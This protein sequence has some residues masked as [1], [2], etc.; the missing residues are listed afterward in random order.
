MNKEKAVIYARVSSKGQEKEGFSIPAQ[1]ELLKDYAQKKNINIVEE[2]VEAES[3]KQA[4]RP[5]FNE[6]LKYLKQHSDVKNILA[7]KTDRLYRNFK[8]YV[9]IDESIYTIHLVKEGSVIAPNATSNEKLMHGFKVL[10]AN[11]FINNLSEETRKGRLKKV[12][13]GYFIGQVPYGYKKLDK[14]TTVLDEQKSKF[15]KRA[16]ELYAIGDISLKKLRK[17]LYNEGYLYTPSS[18]KI[19]TGQLEK[20]LKNECYTGLIRYAGKVFQGKPPAIVD[21]KLFLKAQ[22][23][24]KKDNKPKT[25]HEHLFRYSGLLKCAV[26]GRGVT[27]EVKHNKFVYYHCTGDYG[28]CPN[29]SIYLREE[30]IDEQINEAIKNIVIDESIADYLNSIL[31]ASYKELNIMTKEKHDYFRTEIKQI[32]TRQDKLLDVYLLGDISKELW[33]EKNCQYEKQKERLQN[34]I[35][36]YKTADGKFLNEGKKI[37]ELAKRTYSLYSKQNLEEQRKLLKIVFSNFILNGEKV[38]YEYNRPY[39]LFAEFAKNKRKYARRDSNA[40]PSA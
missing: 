32:Q 17:Q 29:K 26:C 14:N 19:T 3:A 40:R 21:R 33:N 22:N 5:K 7:E 30:K 18:D 15:V 20:I 27:C 13:E 4:G 8:D 36:A 24:F 11:N 2:F 12:E 35:N 28:K 16:F 37:I 39:S 25:Q 10:I 6:M 23:A 1:L 34:Q 9:T 38:S 31:E